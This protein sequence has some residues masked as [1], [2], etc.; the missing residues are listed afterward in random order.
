MKKLS[1]VFA[2]VAVL[3]AFGMLTFLPQNHAP[4]EITLRLAIPQR[5]RSLPVYVALDRGFFQDQKLRI[6]MQE[7]ITG[8]AAVE[9]MIKG[10]VDVAATAQ[11]PAI[12]TILQGRKMWI[13]GSISHSDSHVG[14][15]VGPGVGGVAD[16]KGKRVGTTKGTTND[17]FLRIMLSGADLSIRDVE[18][19]ELSPNEMATALAG[20][21]VDAASNVAGYL[22]PMAAALPG[23][24]VLLSDGNFL[25]YWLLV[26]ADDLPRRNPEAIVRML[27]ALAAAEDYIR[28][29]PD[30]SRKI[31]DR[32]VP[33]QSNELSDYTFALRLDMVIARTM[34]N[35]ARILSGP[36]QPLPNFADYLYTAGL[37]AVRP[38]AV[39]VSP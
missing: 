23:S 27:R 9:A 15:V 38:D 25:D 16:L 10:E 24:K 32:Y 17:L 1:L 31:R 20:G 18:E 22:E 35:N 29:H 39:M 8:K 37:K 5:T 21:R 30:I 14:L 33:G 26:A 6:E 11:A 2:A 4:E 28:A 7:P 34:T 12:G 36:E 19:V 3:L 13:L